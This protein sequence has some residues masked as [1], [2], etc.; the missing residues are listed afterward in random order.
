MPPAV[1]AHPRDV[2]EVRRRC[3]A[4]APPGGS[5]AWR[6]PGTRSRRR[7]YRRRR[8]SRWTAWR[9]PGRRPGARRWCASQAGITLHALSERAAAHGLALREPRRHQRA[10]DRR[11]DRD[12]DARHRRAAAQHLRAGRGGRARR[13][14]RRGRALLGRRRPDAWRAARVSV[15]ALGRHHR[16]DAASACPRSRC[17][18]STRPRRSARRSTA[19]TS[20]RARASTSSSSR[21]PTPTSR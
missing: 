12:R 20:R 15:G 13:R 14:A 18:A 21:S 5:C 16:G 17:A 2:E 11:G 8:C 6:A 7:S 3:A 4:A 10:G 1:I 9:R 19:S